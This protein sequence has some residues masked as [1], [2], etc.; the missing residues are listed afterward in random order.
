M[1]RFPLLSALLL[2][3]S[4]GSPSLYD[5]FVSPD[6][7]VRP[8]CY[9]IAFNGHFDKETID[10]DV[11]RMDSIGF[12]GVLFTDISGYHDG[13]EE[14]LD[15]PAREKEWMGKEWLSDLQHLA[16]R[17]HEREMKL[18]MNVSAHG[19][20]MKGPWD[21]GVDAPKMLVYYVSRAGD[22][23]PAPQ[24]N[25]YS[26][27]ARFAI[28]CEG[29]PDVSPV[30]KTAAGGPADL[31]NDKNL[32][33]GSTVA[34]KVREVIPLSG[35]ED[36][37]ASPDCMILTIGYGSIPGYEHDLDV[38]D[39]DAVTR[40]LTKISEI[41]K[42]ELGPLFGETLT[43]YY[44]VS[45]E[46]SAPTW[47]VNFAE[48]FRRYAGYDI[49]PLL[50]VL[51]GFEMEGAESLIHDFRVARNEMFLQNFYQTMAEV[52]HQYGLKMY[53][54]SGGPW[55][56]TPEA[57]LDADQQRFL[58][59]ND[60]PQ[61]E[62]W[63]AHNYLGGT[64]APVMHMKGAAS[65]AHAYGKNLVSAEAFTHMTYHWSVYPA[66]LKPIA[67]QAMLDGCNHFV[68]HTYTSSPKEFGIPGLEFFAGTHINRNVTWQKDAGSFLTYLTRCQYM[69]RQG[70]PVSDLAVWAG[71]R[72]YQG[73]GDFEEFP[74]DG[75]TLKLPAGYP[76]DIINTETLL[77]RSIAKEGR[78]TLPDGMSYAAVCVDP[79]FEDCLTAEV[80]ER[81]QQLESMGVRVI[82]EKDNLQLGF[83]PDVDGPFKAIHRK[84]DGID[85]YFLK[86][87]GVGEMV[88]RVQNPDVQLWNPVTGERCKAPARILED[89]RS[90]VHVELPHNGSMF[91]VF[92][93][94]GDVE[95]SEE[96][97]GAPGVI[98]GPWEVSFKYMKGVPAPN[99]SPRIWT[100]LKDLTEDGDP[101]VKF[102]SGDVTLTCDFDSSADRHQLCLGNVIGGLAHIYLNGQDC[103]VVWTD[104]W[105]VD[106]SNAVTAGC[107]HLEIV[108]TNCWQNRMIGDCLVPESER[109][110][111]TNV[112]VGQG[113]R[114]WKKHPRKNYYWLRPSVYSRYLDTDT[115]MPSGVLGPVTIK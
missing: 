79:E 74:Y 48:D 66:R 33:S 100:E 46:G 41:L 76:Y 97:T 102:F 83:L 7:I 111:Q 27:L 96:I 39:K 50:P 110:T 103:G 31:A 4:C 73:Y 44:S 61:G 88:F 25:Y 51:C 19:G 15:L 58:A 70:M 43:H 35:K 40:Y 77:H 78:L 12:G 11:A 115:L 18:T 81:L 98:Q 65:A 62:F 38:L 17:L 24:L 14:H 64:T 53:S 85:I 86:G 107:N 114:E 94:G 71:D 108:F 105:S 60:M 91:V 47:S 36:S 72:V 3:F 22:N 106:I 9:Y 16:L 37:S 10:M 92:G 89:G 30:W 2:C 101:S 8:W 69:L 34:V 112:R 5:G 87:E 93:S 56:R 29:A 21:N 49:M 95:S 68:W 67:D 109:V 42:A 75:S 28:R 1:K 20:S 82:R 26:E 63:L 54:E 80:E 113:T 99:P 13:G 59:V 55:T 6:K 57:L 84:Y 32:Q 52:S 90:S 45:W 23:V 104:P